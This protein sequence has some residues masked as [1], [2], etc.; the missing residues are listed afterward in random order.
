[1]PKPVTDGSNVADQI[2]AVASRQPEATAL[3]V[4]ADRIPITYRELV[5][6]TADLAAK[7]RQA[8]LSAGDRVA[9]RSVS[10][11][12]FVIGLLASFD[13]GVIAVPLDPAL[14]VT[15]QQARMATAGARAVLVGASSGRQL[16]GTQE[17]SP[18]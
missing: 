13:A 17:L 9:V 11:A 15:D 3:V 7:L 16:G 8:G 14:P 6:L 2:R 5:E 12:V 4:T 10:D 18:P 1:M